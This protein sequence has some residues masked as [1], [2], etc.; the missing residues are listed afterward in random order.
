MQF[1]SIFLGQSVIKY[2]VPL[3]IFVG[4]NELYDTKKKDLPNASKQLSGK[5]PDEVSLFFAGPTNKKMHQHNHVP[6]DILKW[7]YS[8]FDHY[9]K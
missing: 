8:V 4:L 7:F 1:E 3:E 6:E 9:L 2:Q 5:I